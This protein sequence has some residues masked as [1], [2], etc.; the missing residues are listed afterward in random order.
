MLTGKGSEPTFVRQVTLNRYERIRA[1]LRPYTGAE[2]GSPTSERPLHSTSSSTMPTA[3]TRSPSKMWHSTFLHCSRGLAQFLLQN[4][5][6]GFIQH[7]I[8]A[9]AIA[10]VQSDRQLRLRKISALLHCYA[11]NLLHCR[12]PFYLCFEHVDNLGAYSIPS[13]DRPSHPI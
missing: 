12:S 10:Q 3:I 1:Y 9:R 8:P 2:A 7:A 13:G 6:A 4:N 11:A 5:R